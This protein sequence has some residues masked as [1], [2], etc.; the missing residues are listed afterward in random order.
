MKKNAI[1]NRNYIWHRGSKQ[2]VM[3]HT[4][5]FHRFLHFAPGSAQI[6]Q[7]DV[8]TV[9]S[10]CL[11]RVNILFFLIDGDISKYFVQKYYDVQRN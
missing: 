8:T 1:R 4:C 5:N 6:E 2:M 9:A 10:S 11:K 7:L 3:P